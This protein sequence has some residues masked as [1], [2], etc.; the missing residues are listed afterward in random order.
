MNA[1]SLPSLQDTVD[2]FGLRTKKS[3]GQHFLLNEPLCESIVQ[4]AGD[5]SGIHVIEI[6]PGPGGLTRALLTSQAASIIAVEKDSRAIPALELLLAH[7]NERLRLSEHD[8]LA[9]D[10]TRLCPAPRA[11]I[12]NLPYNIG[13]EL[14]LKWLCH[15]HEDAASFTQLLLM[16]QLEVGE[17][18]AARPGSK[19]YGRLSVLTQWLCDVELRMMVPK[20]AFSPPPKV[21]S[22]MV[23]L[24]PLAKPRFE[25]PKE[26]L[27]KVLVIAFQQRRKML[28]SAL[29]PLG[30][31]DDLAALN[32][33]ETLRPDQL[34]VEQYASLAR[35]VAQ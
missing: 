31:V 21:E 11:I 24:I 23:Q 2:R 12:A 32:I 22:V 14:L 30:I 34:S 3:L 15:L 20:E 4:L 29:K 9:V 25:A 10:A 19:A 17:R 35:R 16:L 28:R 27:E 8:A 5:L 13:T 1:P 18:L 7:S 33:D 26:A 6:G